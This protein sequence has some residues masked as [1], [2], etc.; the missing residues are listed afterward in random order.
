MDL[1]LRTG[2]GLSVAAQGRLAGYAAVYNSESQ[3]L[4]G[5]VEI[6]RPGAFNASLSSGLNIR[7][8]WQ[9]DGKA[10]LGT[11]KAGTLRLKEDTRG[12]GFEL[13]LPGTTIGKDL[14]I[15]VDRGDVAGCSFGFRVRDGGD[16]WEQRGGT[17]VREL[18]D[19]ELV[20][21]TLTD[22]PA[23]MDTSV[24]KRSMPFRVTERT[25]QSLWLETL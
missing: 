4:G 1:E 3:D 19:V 20:E 6:I 12:L 2:N 16:R 14:S 23:Y 9:H 21:I 8:L 7:A 10:L 11:T 18:L 25:L 15:L 17:L 22:D 24:A 5:F 13:D